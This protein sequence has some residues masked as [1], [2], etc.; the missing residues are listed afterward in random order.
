MHRISRHSTIASVAPSR[1]FNH[2]RSTTFTIFSKILPMSVSPRTVMQKIRM[3]AMTFRTVSSSAIQLLSHWPTPTENFTDNHTPRH[4]ATS[5]TTCPIN[6]FFRPMHK[7][8]SRQLS[9]IMS[10]MLID[11]KNSAKIIIL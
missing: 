6:P 9:T 5:E 1:R 8:M 10:N 7:A 3:N 2:P 4:R 11:S